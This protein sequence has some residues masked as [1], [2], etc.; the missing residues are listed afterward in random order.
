LTPASRAA[1]SRTLPQ[2]EHGTAADR[3]KQFRQTRWPSSSFDRAFTPAQRGRAGFTIPAAPA[4]ASPSM[5]RSTAGD[6]AQAPAPVSRSGRATIAQARRR[7]PAGREVACRSAA[8]IVSLPSPGSRAVTS[9]ASSSSGSPSVS[10]QFWQ[11]CRP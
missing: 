8:V 5:N 7:Y 2:R 4:L 10:G 9:L 1:G 6:G 3:A 11:R